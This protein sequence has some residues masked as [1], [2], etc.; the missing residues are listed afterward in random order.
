MPMP[1][2]DRFFADYAAAYERSLGAQVDSDAIRACF[3]EGFVGAGANGE[4][5]AGRND[6]TFVQALVQGYAFYK[7]I[8]TRGM[9]VERVHA[10]PLYEGHD[11]V[12]VFYRAS[13]QRSNGQTLT[14]PFD[15]LYL[16]QRRADGP[17]IF[18]F[19]TGDEMALYKKHGLVNEQ[20]QPT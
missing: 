13:Y 11:K 7:A 2:Y 17:R 3:A 4:V 8:G 20:G 18:A 19:V 9:K 12:Q 1:D 14:S 5:N 16:L 6:D 15:V 10:E